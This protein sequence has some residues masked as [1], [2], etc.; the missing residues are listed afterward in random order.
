MVR[1]LHLY[2][3]TLAI[4]A[5]SLHAFVELRQGRIIKENG[6]VGG[7]RVRCAFNRL[8]IQ[9]PGTA[10]RRGLLRL[11]VPFLRARSY[12]QTHVGLF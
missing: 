10:G 11:C 3:S 4:H 9:A 12:N 6:L 7:V 2:V 5:A 8:V 1:V